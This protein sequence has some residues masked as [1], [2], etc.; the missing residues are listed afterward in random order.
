MTEVLLKDPGFVGNGSD[1]NS[2]MHACMQMV[3]RTKPNGRV[4]S[5]EEIDKILRRKP[6]YYSWPYAIHSAVHREGFD[7]QS[8]GLFSTERFVEKGA[9]YLYEYHDAEAAEVQIKHADMP[10]ILEDARDFLKHCDIVSR[11]H[12]PTVNDIQEA[13]SNG[14]H[15]VPLINPKVL[16]GHPG[17]A[18]HFVFVFGF[19]DQEIIF[20]IR[21][22]LNRNTNHGHRSGF[23]GICSIEPGLRQNRHQDPCHAF[24]PEVRKCNEVATSTP[25]R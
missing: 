15:V 9:S 8:I 6:G 12:L 23:R 17:Y 7:I 24:A 4:F 13:L 1:G 14:W 3:M 21:D 10:T 2:C 16:L 20:M 11:E 18:G 19:N 22:R 25:R 5:F